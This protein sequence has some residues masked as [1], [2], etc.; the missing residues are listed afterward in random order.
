[1]SN[2]VHG[3]KHLRPTKFT[4]EALLIIGNITSKHSEIY[5]D[6]LGGGHQLNESSWE[7]AAS[8]KAAE[9]LRTSMV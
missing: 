3:L 6:P 1:M 9:L 2:V 8:V 5:P 7:E 4:K